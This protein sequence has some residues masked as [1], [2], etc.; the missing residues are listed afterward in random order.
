GWVWWQHDRAE[1]AAEVARQEAEAR[2]EQAR[3][4]AEAAR[5]AAQ[6]ER[7]VLA[8]LADVRR[9]QDRGRWTE[10]RAT[11]RPAPDRPGTLAPAPPRLADRVR[12][13]RKDL[14]LAVTL[15][16]IRGRQ[17]GGKGELPDLLRADSAYARAFTDYGLALDRLDP[18]TA[19][20]RIAASA[21]RAQLVAA[22]GNWYFAKWY[23]DPPRGEPLLAVAGLA[24]PDP[25]RQ[26]LRDPALRRSVP[27]L[28]ELARREEILSQPPTVVVLGRLLG[29]AGAVP[30][31]GTLLRRAGE[32]HPDDFWLNFDLATPLR[33]RTPPRLEEATGYYRVARA[34]RPESPVVHNDLGGILRQQGK[35]VE[36]AA[37][38]RKALDLKEDSAAAHSN[39]ASVLSEQDQLAQA[40]KACRRALEIEPDHAGAHVTLGVLLVLQGRPA[41]AERACRRAREVKPDCAEPYVNLG[42]A[43]LAQGQLPQA[44]TA[45][46]QARKLNPSLPQAYVVRAEAFKRQK[47]WAQ[48]AAELKRAVALQ[49]DY[50]PAHCNLG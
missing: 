15:D 8:N 46:E 19:A 40:E 49:P 9:A 20:Q 39:L 38:L 29:R 41:E 21:L 27:A 18:A 5:Q 43:L 7:A 31:A 30:A 28:E 32:R 36:A 47:Q 25:W 35:L 1:R 37:A 11:P 45:L 48:A 24:D 12:Q 4:A 33:R 26:R 10:A 2:Q 44:L 22:L 6:T 3:R 50:S 42:S 23:G 14:D 13:A 34:L 16:E 17:A